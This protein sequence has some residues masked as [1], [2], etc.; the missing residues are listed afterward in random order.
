MRG[1]CESCPYF[2][3]DSRYCL[4]MG[5]AVEDPRAPCPLERGRECTR[6]TFYQPLGRRCALLDRFVANPSTPP[7][8]FPRPAAPSAPRSREL[9]QKLFDAVRRGDASLVRELLSQGA[10][11]DVRDR[12]GY[13]PLHLAA[14]RG[15]AEIVELLLAYG[16]DANIAGEGDVTPLH[17]AIYGGSAD[18]VRL[19]L[20]YG[21]NP[22]ARDA[23]GRTPYDLAKA[24]GRLDLAQLLEP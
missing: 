21:G 1:S 22:N 19:L 8:S 6:C 3:R 2:F 15:A 14:A 10:D 13:T 7:C 17:V 5:T 20:E 18:V 11:P 24:I 23:G 4:L 9:G 16:A 12:K